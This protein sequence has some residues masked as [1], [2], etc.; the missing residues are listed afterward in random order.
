M[1]GADRQELAFHRLKFPAGVEE[2][3]GHQGGRGRVAQVDL[4]DPGEAAELFFGRIIVA[5]V[6]AELGHVLVAQGIEVGDRGNHADG[7]GHQAGHGRPRRHRPGQTRSR[8]IADGGHAADAVG[9]ANQRVGG[10]PP[11]KQFAEIDRL[12]ARRGG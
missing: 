6:V 12:Q 2:G 3:A 10:M 7:I 4:L 11:V 1:F 8:L 5:V 9:D